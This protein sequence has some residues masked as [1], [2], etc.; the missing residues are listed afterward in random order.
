MGRKGGVRGWMGE[1]GC[2]GESV[3]RKAWGGGKGGVWRGVGGSVENGL[4]GEWLWEEGWVGCMARWE[5]GCV[6][7]L[8]WVRV[9]ERD[10]SV[11]AWLWVRVGEMHGSVRAWLCESM[12]LGEGG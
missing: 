4:V 8:V 2:G 9:G 5:H 10:G 7:V 1:D 11:R 3:G 6:R 12:A